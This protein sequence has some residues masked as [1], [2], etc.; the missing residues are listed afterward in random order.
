MTASRA[1]PTVPRMDT[2]QLSIAY[3]GNFQNK[4]CTEGQ[5][6][7]G[8]ECLG[9]TVTRLATNEHDHESIVAVVRESQPDVLLGAKWNFRGAD[10]PWPDA[11]NQ[12]AALIAECRPFV[13]AVSC[14]HWDCVNKDFSSARWK[15]QQI[16]SE[17]VDLTVLTDGTAA[18]D[19]PR[20][21]VIRDGAPSEIDAGFALSEK[22]E[23]ILFVGSLY[24]QRSDWARAMRHRLGDRFVH[25][26]PGSRGYEPLD[27]MPNSEVTAAELGR[28]VRSFRFVAAPPWPFYR[29]YASDRYVIARAHGGLLIAPTVPEYGDGLI[30]WE[31][32]LSVPMATDRYAAKCAEYLERYD[33]GQLEVIRQ[34]G[35]RHA[36]SKSWELRASEL[37]G[38]LISRGLLKPHGDPDQAACGPTSPSSPVPSSRAWSSGIS[39]SIDSSECGPP[40]N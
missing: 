7:R 11:A 4:H 6:A 25:I 13:R 39:T 24:G 33:R 17:A 31:H 15:W 28:V 40:F 8:L 35:Q 30:E 18:R 32:Y 1:A 37:L 29:G 21:V 20:C 10:G 12:V 34:A 38:H 26:G 16:V 22:I 19:L 9:H 23:G 5:V 36:L 14:W 3:V 27:V 2:N